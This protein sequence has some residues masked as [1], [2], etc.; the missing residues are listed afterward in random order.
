MF[1]YVGWMGEMAE[2]KNTDCG[3]NYDGDMEGKRGRTNKDKGES[4]D[5][6]CVCECVCVHFVFTFQSCKNLWAVVHQSAYS[7]MVKACRNS[8]L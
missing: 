5:L 6:K 7:L 2:V 3:V 4:Q 1:E 8:D